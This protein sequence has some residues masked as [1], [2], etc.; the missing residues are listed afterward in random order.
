MCMLLTQ[1]VPQTI[2]TSISHVWRDVSYTCKGVCH[3]SKHQHH[4]RECNSM[5]NSSESSHQHVQPVQPTCIAKLEGEENKGIRHFRECLPL[6]PNP[7][8]NPNVF[9]LFQTTSYWFKLLSCL[10]LFSLYPIATIA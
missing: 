6:P 10:C 5:D 7:L 4:K 9:F 1:S 2:L 8:S 3:V